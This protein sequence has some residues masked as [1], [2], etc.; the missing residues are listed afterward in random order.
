MYPVDPTKNVFSFIPQHVYLFDAS[1]KQNIHYGNPSATD[2][3][4]FEAAEMAGLAEFVQ[5]QY[6]GF[7]MMIR[8]TGMNLS[9]GERLKVAFARLFLSDPDIII[10][11]EASSALDVENEKAIMAR[12]HEK[13]GDR[14]IISI[15][16]RLHTLK[17][18]D[19]IVV[20][21]SGTVAQCGTHES[22]RQEPGV[23]KTFMDSYVNF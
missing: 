4:I 22:L 15:A 7:N 14:T 9:G 1:L 2:Q 19:K 10:L 17:N 5:S 21:D 11:D 12:L 3:Q 8:E 20:L 6:T 13:F 16:H 23:Y 18:A